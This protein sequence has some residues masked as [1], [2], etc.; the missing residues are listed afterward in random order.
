MSETIDSLSARLRAIEDREAI[1]DIVA[2]YGPL[3]DSGDAA[4]VGDLWTEGGIYEVAGFAA[5]RGHGEIAA[6]IESDEHRAL[7]NDGCAHLLGPVAICL[8][9]DRATARGHSIVFRRQG[10]GFIVYR[11]SANRWILARRVEG[12]RVTHRTNALL[13]G[14]EAARILLAP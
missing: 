8:E 14:S 7:M 4:G 6:L 2:R 12:W 3:A 5:A 10:N 1:R 11:V 9:G 13:D